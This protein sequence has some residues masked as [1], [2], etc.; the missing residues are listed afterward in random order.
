[1]A[2]FRAKKRK[3]LTMA[4]TREREFK[5]HQ[6][7]S[8]CSCK[9]KWIEERQKDINQQFWGLDYWQRRIWIKSKVRFESTKRPR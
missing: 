1:M 6:L 8:P 5:K 7:M 3:R 2:F 9:R 4:E